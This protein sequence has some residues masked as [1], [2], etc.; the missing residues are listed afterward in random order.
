M[1]QQP[2][3]ARRGVDHAEADA[4]GVRVDDADARRVDAVCGEVFE[5]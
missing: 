1:D 3:V 5:C 4:R 2:V